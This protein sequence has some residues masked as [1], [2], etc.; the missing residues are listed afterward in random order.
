MSGAEKIFNFSSGVD[1][2]I[3]LTSFGHIVHFKTSERNN[4]P[5]KKI[6]NVFEV[7]FKNDLYKFQIFHKMF[8]KLLKYTYFSKYSP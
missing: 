1:A 6:K 8:S 5:F 7:D 4:M 3:F 2:L